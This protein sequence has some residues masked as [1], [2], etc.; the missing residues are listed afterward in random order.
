[1][2]ENTYPLV[3]TIPVVIAGERTQVRCLRR[4][5]TDLTK[6]IVVLTLSSGWSGGMKV[7]CLGLPEVC[8]MSGRGL[9]L[10]RLDCGLGLVGGI[11]DGIEMSG[12]TVVGILMSRYLV[13][14]Q[15]L[16]LVLGEGWMDGCLRLLLREGRGTRNYR[17]TDR[18]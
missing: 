3:I 18:G 17:L 9:G 4:M 11:L 1:M 5:L 8:R 16:L 6:D 15:G 13:L 12:K 2:H 10:R 14:S 7:R